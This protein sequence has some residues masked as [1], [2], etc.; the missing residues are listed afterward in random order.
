MAVTVFQID[1]FTDRP[2]AGNPAAVCLL[3][4]PRDA[5]WMQAV[6]AEIRG[7]LDERDLES[8]LR[9]HAGH[10][11]PAGATA[12]SPV[13]V[14]LHMGAGTLKLQGGADG[15]A[16]G[17]IDYNVPSWKPIITTGPDRLLIGAGIRR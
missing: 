15:L 4:E 16:Q 7:L 6:A 11:E 5:A 12:D 10:H 9:S 3:P 8:E 1:A 17:E 13:K 14:T 2:F